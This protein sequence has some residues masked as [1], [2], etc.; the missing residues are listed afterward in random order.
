M[1]APGLE[2]LS[3][4][5]YPGRFII[6]GA[7]PTG[8]FSTV[9]YGITGRSASSQARKLVGEGGTVWT[10]PT[11]PD[12]L[13]RGN[14]ALLIYP[15]VI[16]GSGLAVSNGRQTSDIANRLASSR[17][18]RQ[19]LSSALGAW[20]YEPDSPIYTPRISGC[21]LPDG[22]ASLSIIRRAAEGG[23]VR[24]F[25]DVPFAAGR[26]QFI[27]TYRGG[28]K[29]PISAWEGGPQEVKLEQ[30]STL[31]LASAAYEALAPQVAGPDYRVACAALF[32]RRDASQE[33]SLH[34]I[35][36]WERI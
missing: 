35:N 15:A 23:T 29:D 24:D 1:K 10:K 8:D 4:L 14:P 17:S 33:V 34:I 26:G 5:R 12:I 3:A 2:A 27:S 28:D 18:P 31:A 9:V 30:A 21:L 36:R 16:V 13:K 25:Y 22:R 19:A 20:D 32:F 11:D 6:I 7:D